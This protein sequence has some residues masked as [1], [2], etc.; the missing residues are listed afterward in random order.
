MDASN[1]RLLTPRLSAPASGVGVLKAN[2]LAPST[3]LYMTPWETEKVTATRPAILVPR[4]ATGEIDGLRPCVTDPEAVMRALGV[5]G[6]R[7]AEY[8]ISPEQATSLPAY[9]VMVM[10]QP[11]RKLS[12]GAAV[13]VLRDEGL[14]PLSLRSNKAKKKEP[15][16]E[17]IAAQNE[18]AAAPP[19][20]ASS[21][22][23]AKDEHSNLLPQPCCFVR[24]ESRKK[25]SRGETPVEQR[26]LRVPA[27]DDPLAAWG[28][29][30]DGPGGVT[31][32][33]PHEHVLISALPPA[34][35]A[36]VSLLGSKGAIVVPVEGVLM[37]TNMF[38]RGVDAFEE[39]FPGVLPQLRTAAAMGYSI[40]AVASYP[41]ADQDEELLLEK[42]GRIA[43]L[44]ARW[45]APP[46]MTVLVAVASHTRRSEYSMPRAGLWLLCAAASDVQPPRAIYIGHPNTGETNADVVTPD[47]F[48]QAFATAAGLPLVPV[49]DFVRDGVSPAEQRWV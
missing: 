39:P 25:K 46:P 27:D 21:P 24:P 37:K 19:S 32:R 18:T 16:Q 20:G 5:M 41:S 14:G 38:R 6:R 34:R 31:W 40:V 49:A 15:T 47:G 30:L 13:A 2:N 28:D 10:E 44:H 7:G 22:L 11:R 8:T 12:E 42:L 45:E 26:V 36:H 29:V 48:D 1:V 35:E 9:Y 43:A 33:M 23:A 3:N 17:K 4:T